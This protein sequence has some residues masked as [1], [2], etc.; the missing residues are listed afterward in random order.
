[1]KS[2]SLDIAVVMSTAQHP[3]LTSTPLGPEELVIVMNRKHPLASQRTL[4]PADLSSLRFI[5]YEKN[6]GNAEPD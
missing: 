3:G 4:E 6:T 2:H 1:M 5:L